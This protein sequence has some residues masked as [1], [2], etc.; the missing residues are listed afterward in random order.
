[1]KIT[2]WGTRG[3]LPSPGPETVRYGGNTS[4]VEV[5]SDDGTLLVL[6]AGTGI[7]RLGNAVERDITRID[8]LLTHLHMDH[9]QGF[10]FFGPLY[11]P[12]LEVHVYGPPSTTHD[13][14][15]RLTKYLSPPLF[16]V[17]LRDIPAKLTLHDVPMGAF[18][19]NG[20]R[21]ETALISH[22]GPTVGYRISDAHATLAYLPDHEPAIGNARFPLSA[23]WTSGADLAEGADMLIHDSQYTAEEYAQHIGWGHSAVED[24][25][26]FAGLVGAK[27]LLTFHHDPGHSDEMVD[28]M[29]EQIRGRARSYELIPGREDTTLLINGA[30]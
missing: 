4:C 20:L 25:A 30:S 9:I 8:I 2:L 5:R 27:R 1:M 6:D 14:R 16:P 19:V 23:D 22:P 3:S 28:K 24:T 7:R 18:N 15:T 11:R 21:V 10:G 12:G 26:A 29:M 17:R 13:L